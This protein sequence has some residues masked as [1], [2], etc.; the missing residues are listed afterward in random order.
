MKHPRWVFTVLRPVSAVYV[1]V[2]RKVE[3][4]ELPRGNRYIPTLGMVEVGFEPAYL[5]ESVQMVPPVG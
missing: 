1:C 2:L 5:P 4:P 3:R